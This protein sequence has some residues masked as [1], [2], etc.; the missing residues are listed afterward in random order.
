MQ[1]RTAMGALGAAAF[2]PGLIRTASAQTRPAGSVAQ[3]RQMALMGNQ[4]STQT[5]DLAPGRA[6]H[7]IVKAFAHFEGA[8][9]RSILQAM[10]IAGLPV[11]AMPLPPERMQ[12]VQQLQGLQ[13][14]QFDSLYLRVQLQGHQELLQ[15]H[16]GLV[17]AGTQDEKVISTIAVAGIQQHIAM[18]QGL[19]QRLP[20]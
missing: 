12:V 11:R 16:E 5:S 8:E 9:Q 19:Q 13:G 6:Q 7:D 3:F 14:A 15:A 20:A 18:L 1:R 17:A 10:Q 4:F 2:I